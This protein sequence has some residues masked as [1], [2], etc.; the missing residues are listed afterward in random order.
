[1]GFLVDGIF[2]YHKKI[3]RK[4]GDERIIHAVKVLITDSSGNPRYILGMAED[5]TEQTASLKLDLLFSI[6]RSDILDHLSIIMNSLERAQLKSTESAMQA[7]FDNTIG[8]VELIRNQIGFIRRLQDL[9][10]ISPKWQHAASSFE[11]ALTLLPA[12]NVNIHAELGDFEL[13]ADPLLPRVFYNLLENSLRHGG[14][15]L[16]EIRLFTLKDEESLHLIYQD[17]GIGIPVEQK[18][19]IFEFRQ[20]SGTGMG[21]FL[22]REILGFTGITITENGTPGKGARFEIIVPKEKFRVKG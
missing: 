20:G 10:I 3:T 12:H 17:N 21:M 15:H 11:Y 6:T 9:G 22:V 4:L 1:M 18:H 5:L 19:R 2:R 8:S 13:Y 7:F 14:S 16:T